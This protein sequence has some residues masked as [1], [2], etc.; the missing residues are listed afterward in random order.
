LPGENGVAHNLW[1]PFHN[2]AQ[3]EI[4]DFLYRRN[5]MPATQID[6]LFDLWAASGNDDGTEPPFASHIDLYE[7]IDS[8]QLGDL[9]WICFTI[10]YNGP[11]P[12]DE[13]TVP[14][15]MLME[16]EVWCRDIRLLMRGQLANPDF[17]GE[18]DYTP[19]QIF[20]LTGKREWSN[21]MTG[22]WAWKQA[23]R[24]L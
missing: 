21:V 3:F 8:I 7:A 2:R 15:W 1:D 6:V 23:V 19:L 13:V 17:N 9:P 18:I 10:K 11:L 22:N 5:Q 4:A 16:Y 24:F 20:G 12:D 14:T